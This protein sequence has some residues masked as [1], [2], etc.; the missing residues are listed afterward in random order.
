M[1]LEDSRKYLKVIGVI[2][3]IMGILSA[4]FG[5]FVWGGA[6]PENVV[7]EAVQDNTELLK[8]SY[9][10]IRAVFGLGIIISS[11]IT[12]ITGFMMWGVAKSGR[13]IIATFALTIFGCVLGLA[14]LITGDGL[15]VRMTGVIS[16]TI[17]ILAALAIR[18]IAAEVDQ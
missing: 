16:V 7:R 17:Y 8:H 12:I 1:K 2:V 9:Y 13:N 18:R 15:T 3:M 4:L 14:S 5:V 10:T 6:L 11:F